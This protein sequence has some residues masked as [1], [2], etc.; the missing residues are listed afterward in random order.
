M[1]QAI[2]IRPRFAPGRRIIAVVTSMEIWIF[3]WSDGPGGTDSVRY[4]GAGG[5]PVGEG[6]GQPRAS[7]VCDGAVPHPA[8]YLCGNCDGLVLRF[9]RQMSW[10]SAFTRLSAHPPGD[11]IASWRMSWGFPD[12]R[13][14]PALRAAL[15]ET[16]RSSA[17]GCGRC[18]PFWR[19]ST[20]SSFTEVSPPGR[21]WR[22]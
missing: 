18:L 13:D 19:R 10:M 7:A 22:R 15:R 16:Y 1:D 17:L 8:V 12:W 21:A 5:R 2:V 14:F 6:T 4:P 9:L 11:T 20:S 3:P